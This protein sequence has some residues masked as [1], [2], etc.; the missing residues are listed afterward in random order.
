MYSCGAVYV[1]PVSIDEAYLEFNPNDAQIDAHGS[2]AAYANAIAEELRALI[3]RE[4]QCT[5]RY[6]SNTLLILYYDTFTN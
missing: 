1:Q 3:F 6:I 2:L 4:T 5:V